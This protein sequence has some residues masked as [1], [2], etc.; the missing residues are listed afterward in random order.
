MGLAKFFD[1]LRRMGVCILGPLFVRNLPF[2]LESCDSSNFSPLACGP[3]RKII[4]AGNG[5]CLEARGRGRVEE[6]SCAERNAASIV[7][8]GVSGSA[9]RIGL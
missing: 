6:V 2:G 5:K 7:V 8:Y 3:P 4:N 1:P 9:L